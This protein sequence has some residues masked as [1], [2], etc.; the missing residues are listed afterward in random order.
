MLRFAARAL[1]HM[2]AAPLDRPLA[3]HAAKLVA[4]VPVDLRSALR[5]DAGFGRT[6]LCGRGPRLFEPPGLIRIQFC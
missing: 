3:A 6:Q 4:S 2:A 1:A 5:Q